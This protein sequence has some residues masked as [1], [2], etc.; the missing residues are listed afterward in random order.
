MRRIWS[1]ATSNSLIDIKIRAL[2]PK[3]A[4]LIEDKYIVIKRQNVFFCLFCGG[5]YERKRRFWQLE[6][7]CY[8]EYTLSV[9]LL[10]TAQKQ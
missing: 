5:G 7:H 1:S 2:L 3:T 6:T 9:S 8:L 10:S 4:F